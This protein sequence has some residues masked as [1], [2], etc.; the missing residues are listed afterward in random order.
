MPSTYDATFWHQRAREAHD[1]SEQMKDETA[2]GGMSR[3][4]KKYERI[5][6]QSAHDEARIAFESAREALRVSQ[7]AASEAQ[8]AVVTKTVDAAWHELEKARTALEA[9][10]RVHLVIVEGVEGVDTEAPAS[11]AR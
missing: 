1:L 2:R 10:R 4:A 9:F 6:L 3:L 7:G 5:A 8:I 11:S